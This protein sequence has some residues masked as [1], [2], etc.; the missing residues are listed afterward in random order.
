MF[1]ALEVDGENVKIA[2]DE[3]IEVLTLEELFL[4]QPLEIQGVSYLK[5]KVRVTPYKG[6]DY[7]DLFVSARLIMSKK[8][9]YRVT[10][11]VTGA[12][13]LFSMAEL[14]DFV[15]NVKPVQ[16]VDYSKERGFY[17]RTVSPGLVT[18]NSARALISQ[19]IKADVTDSGELVYLDIGGVDT[20]YLHLGSLCNTLRKHCIVHRRDS[21][22][23]VLKFDDRIK[24]V[25]PGWCDVK[26]VYIDVTD[27]TDFTVKSQVYSYRGTAIYINNN[28]VDLDFWNFHHSITSWKPYE[29]EYSENDILYLSRFKDKMLKQLEKFEVPEIY[30][31]N[32]KRNFELL[33]QYIDEDTVK[34]FTNVRR[35]V[36]FNIFKAAYDKPRIS[37]IPYVINGGRDEDLRHILRDKLYSFLK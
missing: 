14:Q 21:G 1:Y 19:G 24:K 20:E 13:R 5:T 37:V 28:P 3:G 32:T 2:G 22:K 25:Y 31:R 23:P 8:V 7:G 15:K 33:V 18:G 11:T 9:R 35:Q 12:S 17:I 10:N 36:A 27:L 6:F 34:D 16:G 4:L 26:G 29:L 30:T